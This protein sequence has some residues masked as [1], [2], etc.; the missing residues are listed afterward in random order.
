MSGRRKEY[1]NNW[2]AIKDAPTEYFEGCSWEEFEIFKLNGWEI[3]SSHECIIRAEH[4]DTGKITEHSYRRAS[5]AQDRLLKY[6][7]DGKHILTVCNSDAI[8][9]LK[10]T[11]YDPDAD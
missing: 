8:H 11:D 3:P 1:P 6:L 2:K 10:T 7:R 9:L 5:A 4:K